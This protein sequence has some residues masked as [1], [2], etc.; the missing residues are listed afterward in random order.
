MPSRGLYPAATDLATSC[1]LD[2]GGTAG[3]SG[4][5][6]ADPAGPRRDHRPRRRLLALTL[7]A[8]AVVAFY[9]LLGVAEAAFTSST[10]TDASLDLAGLNS[11]LPTS[12]TASRTGSTS[13]LVSW[14]PAAGVPA[15]SSYDVLDGSGTA[16]TT[17]ASGT[18]V[19]VTAPV[20]RVATSVRVRNGP[21]VSTASVAT[22]PACPGVPGAPTGVSATAADTTSSVSWAAPADDGGSAITSYT[23]TAVPSDGCRPGPARP[24]P[25]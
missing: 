19:T 16:L 8:G 24:P 12:A 7:S 14:T 6:T 11:H 15:G 17:G 2:A 13:C 20:T 21:W 23:A 25:R 5:A 1:C 4:A 22:S 10:S 3:K 9:A 18:S